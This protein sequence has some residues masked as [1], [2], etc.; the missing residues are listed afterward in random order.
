MKSN[1]FLLILLISLTNMMTCINV[2]KNQKVVNINQNQNNVGQATST[3]N[4][5][6]QGTNNIKTPQVTNSQ[7]PSFG[8]LSNTQNK[9][10]AA[11]ATK[12]T[13]PTFGTQKKVEQNQPTNQASIGNKGMQETKI[14]VGQQ[15]NGPINQQNQSQ[16]QL[17]LNQQRLVN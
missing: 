15:G 8:G 1:L 2:V 13:V 3:G 4:L 17:Q 10:T 14:E 11:D 6:Q 12:T 7:T 16:P 9:N 5:T